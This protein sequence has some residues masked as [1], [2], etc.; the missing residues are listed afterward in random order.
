MKVN[1]HEILTGVIPRTTDP[2]W[3]EEYYF[4]WNKDLFQTSIIDITVMDRDFGKEDD[5]IGTL[6]IPL[7]D[8][9]LKL[10]RAR[11]YGT[12]KVEGRFFVKPPPVSEEELKDA[13]GVDIE[14][15]LKERE[16]PSLSFN[17]GRLYLNFE[18]YEDWD[19][20]RN[21]RT[22][23]KLVLPIVNAGSP[24]VT[25]YHEQE[26]EK[27][28]PKRL[29][30]WERDVDGVMTTRD[31]RVE[32]MQRDMMKR[33]HEFEDIE[34]PPKRN[35]RILS[36]DGGGVRGVVVAVILQSLISRFP[37]LLQEI[38]VIAGTSTGGMLAAL[39]GSGCT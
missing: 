21:T 27:S 20:D 7:Q 39:L 34:N 19:P 35:F 24:R 37:T 12:H 3:A 17:H 22:G 16:N 36:I 10:R 33:I 9:G 18:Y 29:A 25:H 30:S 38:D 14:K 5:M 11:R 32:Q 2:L 31:D 15:I 4:E 8:I 23:N 1:D 13:E 28:R 26:R 6:Q